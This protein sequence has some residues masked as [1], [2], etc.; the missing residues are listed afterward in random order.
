M[1]YEYKKLIFTCKNKECKSTGNT[2]II[3]T[4]VKI[5]HPKCSFCKKE[6]GCEKNKS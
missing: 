5:K 3:E 4:D 1:R 6:M 2:K